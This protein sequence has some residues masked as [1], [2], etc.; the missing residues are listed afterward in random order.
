M[1]HCKI[2]NICLQFIQCLQYSDKYSFCSKYQILFQG[3]LSVVTKALININVLIMDYFFLN[4]SMR[5]A[6]WAAR[7]YKLLSKLTI[8]FLS[9]VPKA[10]LYSVLPISQKLMHLGNLF[11][12][13]LVANIHCFL[14]Y[15]WYEQTNAMQFWIRKSI[16]Q[17]PFGK[18]W[19]AMHYHNVQ[20]GLLGPS[21]Y[22]G[23]IALMLDRC[24]SF[25]INFFLSTFSDR[26]LWNLAPY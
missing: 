9:V 13:L 18:Y 20:V 6:F 7:K 25:F 24:K 22:F 10:N 23:E 4:A 17:W 19:T 5:T 16:A 11:G 14:V 12:N 1:V 2:V 3:F 21:D 15:F 26:E 8:C